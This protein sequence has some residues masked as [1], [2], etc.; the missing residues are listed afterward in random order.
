MVINVPLQIDDAALEGKLKKEYEDKVSEKVSRMVISALADKGDSWRYGNDEVRAK[1][2]IVKLVNQRIDSYFEDHKDEICD[3][4]V[5]K[6]WDRAKNRK[7]LRE[8][9]NSAAEGGLNEA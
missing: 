5:K 8:A 1:D 9:A 3:A 7:I 6:L 2:G 4:I